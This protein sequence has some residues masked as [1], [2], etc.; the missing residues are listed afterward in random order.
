[1]A[2]TPCAF[3]QHRD[4]SFCGASDLSSVAGLQ[5]RAQFFAEYLYG[6]PNVLHDHLLDVYYNRGVHAIHAGLS[7]QAMYHFVQLA[8]KVGTRHDTA[9]SFVAVACVSTGSPIAV[10][11]SQQ[12]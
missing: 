5:C 6:F 12:E 7:L 2:G 10:S 8:R 4:F 1:L 11:V 9:S 3:G